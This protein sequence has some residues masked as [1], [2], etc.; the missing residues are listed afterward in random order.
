M[1]E[2]QTVL[3]Y[4]NEIVKETDTSGSVLATAKNGYLRAS[5]NQPDTTL[6]EWKMELKN[7]C[8][9]CGELRGGMYEN[10]HEQSRRVYS[11]EGNAPSINTQDGGGKEQKILGGV[12]YKDGKAYRVR[13]LT[14]REC[15][16][17][18]GVKDEDSAKIM[19]RQS[20]SGSYH[21]AGDSIV[22][23]VLCAIFGKLYG[24]TDEEIKEKVDAV[25]DDIARGRSN[26]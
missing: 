4:G 20:M 13:R 18:M 9:Q 26:G 12:Y 21:L 6:V 17:L 8:I 3:M 15:F 23:Q 1:A 22:C 19:K 25:A 16:R 10:T 11:T 14:E 5:K 2:R 24:M 7:E